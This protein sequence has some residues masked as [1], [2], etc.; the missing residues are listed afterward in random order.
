MWK[1]IPEEFLIIFVEGVAGDHIINLYVIP[2]AYNKFKSKQFELRNNISQVFLR[3]GIFNDIQKGL[4]I[5]IDKRISKFDL[6]G[7]FAEK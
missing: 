1:F 6:E 2:K 7:I 5:L 4:T 3:A